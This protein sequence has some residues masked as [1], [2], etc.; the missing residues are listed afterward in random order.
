[1]KTKKGGNGEDN[2]SDTSKETERANQ[3]RCLLDRK[4]AQ[5][6]RSAPWGRQDSPLNTFTTITK[7]PN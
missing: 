4:C 1:M 5:G 7:S 3:R 2:D 6:T